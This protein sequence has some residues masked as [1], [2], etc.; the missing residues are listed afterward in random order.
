[1]IGQKQSLLLQKRR[2][3][4]PKSTRRS[5]SPT[6]EHLKGLIEPSNISPLA[7]LDASK[8]SEKPTKK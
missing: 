5:L 2:K 1:M 3:K 7:A 8:I 4:D 6:A